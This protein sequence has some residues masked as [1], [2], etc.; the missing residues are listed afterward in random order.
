MK[1]KALWLGLAILGLATSAHATF[2]CGTSI[3]SAEAR[4]GEVLQK[5]GPPRYKY[6]EEPAPVYGAVRVSIWVYGPNGG[7][8]QY[9]RFI[10]DKL[11]E[12]RTERKP[13]L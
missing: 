8:W 5:C 4:M 6:V 3:V 1:T 13:P 12:Q 11:V 10:E 7:A 2:R 9:L